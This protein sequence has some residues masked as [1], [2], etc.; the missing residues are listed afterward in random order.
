MKKL[1]IVFVLLALGAFA[2]PKSALA[3]A[4]ATCKA[5]KESFCIAHAEDNDTLT[6]RIRNS[7]RVRN[8]SVA[9][10][11]SGGNEI[12][13]SDDK[14]RIK[15]GDANASTETTNTVNQTTVVVTQN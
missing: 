11:V 4:K 7:A 12:K 8:T 14:N 3:D 10:A 1:F 15:S 2:F 13:N 9:V 6:V 5:P